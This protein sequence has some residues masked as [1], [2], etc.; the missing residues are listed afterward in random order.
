M[1]TH[2]TMNQTERDT[3]VAIL[4]SFL[5]TPHGKLAEL[6]PLHAE[7]LSR[8][9]MFYG[10]MAVALVRGGGGMPASSVR[11]H[12][13]LAVA[14]L[15]VSEFPEYREAAFALLQDFP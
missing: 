13:V 3:R 15:F 6:A 5:A 4:T 10:P 1:T 14:H 8:D 11:D 2:I 7:A 9:P 12:K